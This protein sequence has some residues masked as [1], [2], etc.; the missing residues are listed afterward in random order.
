M[1]LVNIILV[2]SMIIVFG[3]YFVCLSIAAYLDTKN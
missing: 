2:S 3:G 1:D